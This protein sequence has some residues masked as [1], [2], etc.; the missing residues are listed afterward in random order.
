MVANNEL[1]RTWNEAIMFSCTVLD[2]PAEYCGE[3][4]LEYAIGTAVHTVTT[5][6]IGTFSFELNLQI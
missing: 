1:E 4:S 3:Q 2:A 6:L 5:C